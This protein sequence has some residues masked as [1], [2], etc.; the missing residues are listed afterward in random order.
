[1][2]QLNLNGGSLRRKA[3]PI[4]FSV[5]GEVQKSDLEQLSI[6]GDSKAPVRKR[7]TQRHHRTAMYLAQG[8][9]PGDVA[10][11]VGYGAPTISILQADPLFQR[12]VTLYKEKM[13]K[14]F[15]DTGAKLSAL[16]NDALDILQQRLEDDADG[17]TPGQLMEMAKLGAD[18]TGFGPASKVETNVNV[19]LSSRM[20]AAWQRH[21]ERLERQDAETVPVVLEGEVVSAQP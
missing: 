11:L 16:T 6:K 21:Q 7:M 3:A 12:L 1:M 8:M 17:F 9:K 18:R 20:A 13:D 15:E 2:T 14:Y 4:T 10:I 19:N 5:L